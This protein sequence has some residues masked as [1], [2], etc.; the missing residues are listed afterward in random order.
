[1]IEGDDGIIIVDPER[2]STNGRIIENQFSAIT[3][4]PVENWRPLLAQPRPA[5][6]LVFVHGQQDEPKWLLVK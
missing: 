3:D 2:I 1:M 5:T 6:F 4:K